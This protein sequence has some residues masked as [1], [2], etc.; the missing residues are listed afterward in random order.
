MMQ[1]LK[2]EVKESEWIRYDDSVISCKGNWANIIEQCIEA[3]CYP[4]VLFFE[5][6]DEAD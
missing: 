1:K 6:V 2:S 4:T 5:R 3:E